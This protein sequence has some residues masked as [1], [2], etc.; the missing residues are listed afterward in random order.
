MDYATYLASPYWK[1]KKRLVYWKRGRRC[2]KCG[3]KRFLQ[4]H[5]KTYKRLGHEELEDLLILCRECHRNW[6]GKPRPYKERLADIRRLGGDDLQ[7]VTT[8][9]EHI[10]GNGR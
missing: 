9:A 2:E 10:G 4:V 5:H 8:V 7:R 1:A 6:H 3:S